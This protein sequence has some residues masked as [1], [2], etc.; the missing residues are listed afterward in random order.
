LY[1]FF[2]KYIEF[3]LKQRKRDVYS[4]TS[5]FSNALSGLYPL[6]ASEVHPEVEA[7]GIS[8]SVK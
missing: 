6:S 2:G 1:Q 7:A 3:G 8:N 5:E 4:K